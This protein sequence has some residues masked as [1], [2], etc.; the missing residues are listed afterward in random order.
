[1]SLGICVLISGSGSNL[2]AIIHAVERGQIRAVIKRVIS[3][4]PDVQGLERAKRAGINTSV[5]NH[6]NYASRE[7]F[8]QALR[9]E[10]DQ[11]APGLVVLAG[12]MRI[13]TANFTQAYAGRMLNIH[14]SLLPKYKGLHTHEQALASGDTWHG[15]S[16]HYVT[17]DLDGG[18]VICQARM[19]VFANDTPQ[20]LA[21]RVL[22]LEHQLY[23]TVIHWV[24]EKWL[25]LD[26]G[27]V[28]LMGYP[29]EAPLYLEELPEELLLDVML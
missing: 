10:I 17:A 15:A 19:A 16:V 4:V 9:Q 13:L 28:T 1:M 2:Q 26:Q 24:A 11:D 18:P 6:K 29:L 20:S 8:E 3:N 21:S 14:P 12:F 25:A 5:V 27:R 22:Q 23:P 7:E